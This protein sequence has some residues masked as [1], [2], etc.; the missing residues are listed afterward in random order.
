[1]MFLN[2]F[3]LFVAA[4]MKTIPAEAVGIAGQLDNAPLRRMPVL[5]TQNDYSAH[6]QQFRQA[7]TFPSPSPTEPIPSASSVAPA[8]SDSD[9]FSVSDKSIETL[10]TSNRES[11]KKKNART[12]AVKTDTRS[13]NSGNQQEV[14]HPEPAVSHRDDNNNVH[15]DRDLFEALQV[16]KPDICGSCPPIWM[17]NT[18]EMK[19]ICS[20]HE[21]VSSFFSMTLDKR[22][23]QN[24]VDTS[25]LKE[26]TRTITCTEP[27][28][29]VKWHESE[30]CDVHAPYTGSL[31]T[32]TSNTFIYKCN[33]TQW[34]LHG[35]PLS[36]VVCAVSSN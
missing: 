21:S 3:V 33:G 12:F 4:C 20:N 2:S 14:N 34:T 5:N 35:F 24:V 18:A 29:L 32:D 19:E 15:D 8:S 30:L 10:R 6:I 17:K 26:C 11:L 13:E 23:A 31:V 16:E 22:D 28:M 27:H 25:D 7:K 36:S 1:M 9:D